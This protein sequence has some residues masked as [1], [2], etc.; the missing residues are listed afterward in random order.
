MSL[1]EAVRYRNRLDDLFNSV[2]T[3]GANPELQS[4]WAKYLCILVS[5]YLEVAIKEIYREFVGQRAD[6]R[7]LSFVE[8]QLNGFQNPN[9]QK[10]S[11]LAGGFDKDWG[12][13]ISDSLDEELRD[14]INSIVSN[15]H[16]IAH[17][18]DVGLS[19][20][21]MRDYYQSSLKLVDLIKRQ[22]GI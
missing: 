2:G 17:G 5:G 18:R 6:R 20:T 11:E 16:Q 3:L 22:C 1:R 4:H 19:Y 7:V 21:R 13:E 15:R 14:H 12:K 8:A 10:I 9:V